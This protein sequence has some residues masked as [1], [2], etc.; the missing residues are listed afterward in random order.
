MDVTVHTVRNFSMYDRDL[1]YEMQ[2]KLIIVSMD[3]VQ[4]FSLKLLIN[5]LTAIGLT[6]GGSSTL[7]AAELCPQQFNAQ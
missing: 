2:K 4:V 7:R 1:L 3:I 6:P 5:L